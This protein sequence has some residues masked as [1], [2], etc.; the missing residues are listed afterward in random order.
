MTELKALVFDL[1]GTLVDFYQPLMR[2][3]ADI[4]AGRAQPI[5][6]SAFSVRWRDR[7]RRAMD[8]ILAGTS[9]WRTVDAIYRTALDDLLEEDGST[10]SLTA[11]ERDA[12]NAVWTR[13]EPWPDSAS[14]LSRLRERFTTAT[15]TNASMSAAIAVVKHAALPFDAVLSAELVRSYKPAEAVYRLAVDYLGFK[16]DEIM[17]VACHKYDLHAGHAFGLRT[18]FIA[19]SLEFGPDGR[20]DTQPDTTFDIN[21]HDVVDLAIRLDC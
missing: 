3:G 6:W 19:R 8:A 4:N 5:D 16:A 1:Q 14:G 21:A 18:A 10:A 12:L 17:L 15:L 7:Y 13:L 11:R 2:A 9:P 20:P